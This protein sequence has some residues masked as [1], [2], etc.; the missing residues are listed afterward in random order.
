MHAGS[1]ELIKV[2]QIMTEKRQ[3]FKRFFGGIGRI[4]SVT[5]AVISGLFSLIFIVFFILLASSMFGQQQLTIPDDG[6]LRIEIDGYLVDQR[7]SEDPLSQLIAP[8]APRQYVVRELIEAIEMAAEDERINSIILVLHNMQGGGTSKINELGDSL[9]VFSDKGKPVLAVSDFYNQQQYLLASYADEIVM[10]PFGMVDIRGFA[11]YQSYLGEALE[12]LSVNVHVF[13]T[14]EYKDAVEPF[15]ASSMSEASRL[16]NQGLLDDIWQ[17]Y[18]EGITQRRQLDAESLTNYVE[19]FDQLLLN[20]NG[21]AAQMALNAGLVDKVINRDES[22]GYSMEI[23]GANEDGDFYENIDVMPYYQIESIGRRQTHENKVGLIVASGTIYDGVQ[24]AGAIGGDSLAYALRQTRE[25]NEIDALVLRVDS[26]GGSAFASE[27]IRREIELM[28][29]QGIP[30]VVSMGSVAASGGYWIATAA[31]HIVATPSTITGSIGVF[32]LFPTLDESLARLGIYSDG[33]QT[34][35]LAGALQ[36]DRPL[37]ERAASVVQSS[38]E[39][40]Y[41]RFLGLVSE[42]RGISVADLE[43]IAGGRVWS[44]QQ[45]LELQLVDELGN[46]ETAERAAARLADIDDYS[47]ELIE[48]PM[49]L[50]ERIARIWTESIST[51]IQQVSSS[52]QLQRLANLLEEPIDTSLELTDPQS[53]FL[54]CSACTATGNL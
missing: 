6:A 32:S 26:P 18:L 21:N 44:G 33:V 13:R 38:V 31:N 35:P 53:I 37:D 20:E 48:P 30:V 50:A 45:A 39:F 16:Q 15:I 23:A 52:S 41:D 42:A 10:H 5:R 49:S 8:S 11:A 34:A 27:V 12:K 17:T 19:Q 1:N 40:I 46:Q 54:Y 2:R 43:S 29:E 7:S 51:L 4:L 14:G 3:A 22:L 36:I 47:V 28:R 24:G 9:Q 25:E